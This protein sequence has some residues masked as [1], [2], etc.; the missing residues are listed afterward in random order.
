[1]VLGGK[2]W[3]NTS[4][5]FFLLGNF[6]CFVFLKKKFITDVLNI[7]HSSRI[8]NVHRTYT[9]L[10]FWNI[11]LR[12][13]AKTFLPFSHLNTFISNTVTISAQTTFGTESYRSLST[14]PKIFFLLSRNTVA[15]TY[16]FLFASV[17]FTST[18]RAKWH[19]HHNFLFFNIACMSAEVL[20]YR[21]L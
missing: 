19:V 14:N 1:M 18:R 17:L 2:E 7:Y 13:L 16:C 4:L 6:F 20:S 12:T 8:V 9:T 21:V 10:S 5:I 15:T 3:K 11:F